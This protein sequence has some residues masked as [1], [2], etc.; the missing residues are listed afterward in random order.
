MN[1]RCC[2]QICDLNVCHEFVCL[3]VKCHMSVV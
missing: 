3:E 1:E 2:F